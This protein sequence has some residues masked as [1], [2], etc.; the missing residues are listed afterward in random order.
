MKIPTYQQLFRIWKHKTQAEVSGEI[1]QLLN[2]NRRT[3]EDKQQLSRLRAR[4]AELAQLAEHADPANCG[5]LLELVRRAYNDPSAH[6]KPWHGQW[7]VNLDG[8]DRVHGN[9]E[10]EA[11]LKA[12]EAAPTV[13]TARGMVCEQVILNIKLVAANGSTQPASIPATVAAWR[14]GQWAIHAAMVSFGSGAHEVPGRA[15]VTHIPTGLALAGNID[16]QAAASLFRWAVRERP[17]GPVDG[18]AF[19]LRALNK[20]AMVAEPVEDWGSP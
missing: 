12:L 16:T 19:R 6:A 10:V 9:T 13:K 18:V 1:A 11:L 5:C 3:P 20:I 15:T 14:C 8:Y 4:E 7:I 17:S 2:K